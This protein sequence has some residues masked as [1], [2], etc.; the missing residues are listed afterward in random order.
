MGCGGCP[1]GGPDSTG[2][3]R[4]ALNGVLSILFKGARSVDEGGRVASP[5]G[6]FSPATEVGI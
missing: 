1:R 4:E 5:S 2:Q 6:A 3:E